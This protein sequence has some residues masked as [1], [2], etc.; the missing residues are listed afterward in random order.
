MELAQDLRRVYKASSKAEAERAL[1][2]VLEK[3][4]KKYSS[5]KRTLLSLRDDLLNFYDFPQELWVSIYTTNP[6]E[7]V[8][9]ELKRRFRPV[10]LLP[11]QEA[12]EKLAYLVC[13]RVN[14]RF[15][16]RRLRRWVGW[17]VTQKS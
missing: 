14:E 6:I 12:A 3:W 2:A 4:G 9:Q 5:V 17:E 8:I 10:V 16:K 15:Q 13:L 1:E 7:R 11:N